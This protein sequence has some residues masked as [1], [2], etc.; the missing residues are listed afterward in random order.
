LALVLACTLCPAILGA[1]ASV[2]DKRPSVRVGIARLLA[3]NLSDNQ[4]TMTDTIP[5][6]LKANLETLKTRSLGEE[7]REAYRSASLLAKIRELGKSLDEQLGQYD[8]KILSEKT[9]KEAAA[10]RKGL[11]PGILKARKDLDDYAKIPL[12]DI[13]VSVSKPIDWVQPQGG[14]EVLEAPSSSQKAYCEKQNLDILIS[15]SLKGSGE[16]AFLEVYAYHRYL[17]KRIFEWKTALAE[18][19][20]Q[21]AIDEFSAVLAQSLLGRETGTLRVS[22][23]PERAEI[24][25]NGNFAGNSPSVTPFADSGSYS[26]SVSAPGYV[27]EERTVSVEAGLDAALSF[28]LAALPQ[29]TIGVTSMPEGADIY[30]EGQKIGQTPLDLRQNGQIRSFRARKEGYKDT[31]FVVD[32]KTAGQLKVRLTGIEESKKNS[33]AKQKDR[34]YYA[35]GAFMV[36]LPFSVLCV[37]MSNQYS[38]NLDRVNAGTYTEEQKAAAASLMDGPG[39]SWR[40]A[41]IGASA[42]SSGLLGFAVYRFFLYLNS[43][44]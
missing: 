41:A 32:G 8:M 37:G 25:I 4:K 21:S 28:D 18:D 38:S 30:L 11:K 27:S 29:P 15:G 23:R 26:V 40:L 10:S 16:Y 6:R 22:A 13:E 42:L 35:A 44:Q 31:S 2:A 20:S 43:S 7:E 19:D 36:S 17:D 1:Q 12:S 39:E 24:R 14:A 5:M 33:F 34:F 9:A 3:E